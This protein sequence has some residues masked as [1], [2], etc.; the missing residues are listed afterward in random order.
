MTYAILIIPSSVAKFEI[1]GFLGNGSGIDLPDTALPDDTAAF[2]WDFWSDTPAATH[3]W[4]VIDEPV[5][6]DEAAAP[7]SILAI[8]P[9]IIPRLYATT[10]NRN[11]LVGANHSALDDLSRA[12]T[13]FLLEPLQETQ[14]NANPTKQ[15]IG[16]LNQPRRLILLHHLKAFVDC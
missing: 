14:A 13:F 4:G 11:E 3:D 8:S 1:G 2:P 12:S 6:I 7:S 15:T 10:P 9:T 16:T 5:Q